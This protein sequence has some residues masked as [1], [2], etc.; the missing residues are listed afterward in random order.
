MAPIAAADTLCAS[1]RAS[2]ILPTKDRGPE[3]EPTLQALLEQDLAQSDYEVLIVDNASSD[4]NAQLLRTWAERHAPLLRYH[5]EPEPGLNLAR[6]AG[7]RA[8]TGEVLAFLDD[9]AVAPRH[10][11]RELLQCLADHPKT[12]AVGGRIVSQFTS[13]PPAWLD[14]SLAIYLSDFDRGEHSRPLHFDDY[15]RGAN[16]AFRREAFEEC[17]GFAS[18]LDRKGDLLLSYGDIEMCYRVEQAGH[19]VRYA[20]KADVQHLIRGDRLSFDWFARRAYWQGRSQALFERM[21]FGR[22][23]LLRKWPYRLLRS[24]ISDDRYRRAMHRGLTTGT[25]RSILAAIEPARQLG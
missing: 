21:H 25:L 1:M 18:N 24:V 2:V 16:M 8:A 6:N 9:D 11:L 20:P 7:I 15:P 5:P 4:K 19:E 13:A 12:W 3:I 23:H 22:W 14:D 10:W 17:G